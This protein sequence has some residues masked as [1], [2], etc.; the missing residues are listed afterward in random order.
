MRRNKLIFF[1][2][3]T[4]LG[5]GQVHATNY[6]GVDYLHRWMHG[7]DAKT[8]AMRLVLLEQYDSSE[9]YFAHR[10]DNGV[11]LSL[12]FE[13]SSTRSKAH[14]FGA[15]ENFLGA[16]QTAGD[17]TSISIKVRAVNIDLNGYLDLDLAKHWEMVG[18]LGF[19]LMQSDM[20]GNLFSNGVTNNLAPSHN[21]YPVP[22]IGFGFQYF[23]TESLGIRIIGHWLGTSMF[24]QRFTDEDGVRRTIKP[25]QSSWN[26]GF[27]IVTRF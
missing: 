7:R 27:G 8:Y 3:C 12:G 9:F 16:P 13:Q 4:M 5:L 18:Q 24:Q 20:R 14:T 22:R 19:A 6:F 1:A 2:V 25:F 17:N 23:C 15:D 10:F 21:L 11:G 26:V